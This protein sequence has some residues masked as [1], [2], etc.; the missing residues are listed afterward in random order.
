MWE[1]WNYISKA[2]KLRIGSWHTIIQTAIQQAETNKTT[3]VEVPA[4]IISR[5]Y[6]FI[7][8]QNDCCVQEHEMVGMN[9]NKANML[10]DLVRS[11]TIAK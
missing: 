6:A 2:D 1:W 5:A 3:K 8:T 9:L 7:S 11:E 10:F 4:T